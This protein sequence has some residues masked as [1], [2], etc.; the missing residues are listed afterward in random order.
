MKDSYSDRTKRMCKLSAYYIAVAGFYKATDGCG[1]P[2]TSKILMHYLKHIP[3]LKIRDHPG[4]GCDET[5][6]RPWL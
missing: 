6:A 4:H 5:L 1:I 3:R 2:I